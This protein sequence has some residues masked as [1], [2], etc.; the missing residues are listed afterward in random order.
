MSSVQK[1][2]FYATPPHKCSYLPGREAVTL[3][4]DPQFPKN[5][6]VYS[7]LA[8][9]GFRRS[10][11]HLY[12][13]HC[14]GCSS[15][16]SVRIPVK[17]F[18]P[19]RS[20]KRTLKKNADLTI[21]ERPAA[22]DQDHFDL[23]SKYLSSRHQDG[24]MDNPSP[25]GYMDFLTAAWAHTVFYEFRLDERLLAV[26]VTDVMDNGLSAV[27]TFYDPDAAYRSPGK[28]A[29]L[30]QID[31]A[32]RM[33]RDWVYLGYWIKDCAKMSYKAEFRPQQIYRDHA[34]HDHDPGRAV[35][36]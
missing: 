6:R 9:C 27:Y 10:G 1:I 19:S 24:G 34:W 22:F 16:I 8:D 29:I 20:Q 31:R 21:R 13:P 14:T 33:G 2:G 4:A 17:N 36:E 12:I 26:A 23:Y 11:T 25:A 32:R 28:F 5:M 15:C 30:L 3:F 35:L 18:R 7:A